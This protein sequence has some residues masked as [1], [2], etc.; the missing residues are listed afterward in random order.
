MKKNTIQPTYHNVYMDPFTDYGFK[1]LFGEEDSKVY[2][3]DF[4]NSVLTGFLPEISE[5]TYSKNEHLGNKAIDRN[6]VFDLYCKSP[7]GERF[8]IELQKVKQ[9][10]FTQRSLFYSIFAIQEQAKK[11]SW[12]FNLAPVYCIGILNFA[13]N[14]TPNNSQKN[15]TKYITKAKILD[16]ETHAT[17]IEELNFAFI[18][19]AKFDKTLNKDSSKQDKWLYVLSHLADLQDMPSNLSEPLF[20][21]FFQKANVLKLSMKEQSL[22]NASLSY[23]RDLH[24]IE[25][26]NYAKGK[27]EGIAEGEKKGKAEGIAEGKK[28]TLIQM[29]RAF[30][31]QG[32]EIRIIMAATGLTADEINNI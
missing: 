27:E 24:N 22:Y 19:C 7:K 3:I 11:G 5:L 30:K 8:I 21:E 26:Q 29:V 31:A 32:V 23:A 1:K 18:E 14:D 12:D 13:L 28:E 4:L 9:D 2:L 20:E 16:V 10:Y 6:A 15:A 17:V 25:A